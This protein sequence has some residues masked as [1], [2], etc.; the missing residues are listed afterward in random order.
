MKLHTHTH[1]QNE[2]KKKERER[3][4]SSLCMRQEIKTAHY[5]QWFPL[6]KSPAGVAL[7]RIVE[8]LLPLSVSDTLALVASDCRSSS[9]NSE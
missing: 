5:V 2:I 1:T 6:L 9:D 3:A 7:F 4:R 8:L